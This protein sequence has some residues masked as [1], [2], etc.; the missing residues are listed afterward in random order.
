MHVC[1]FICVPYEKSE[2]T[3]S[4]TQKAPLAPWL[5]AHEPAKSPMSCNCLD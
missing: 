3:P 2:T 5:C 1:V 4:Q